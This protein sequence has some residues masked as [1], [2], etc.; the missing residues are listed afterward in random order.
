MAPFSGCA[1][2]ARAIMQRA[3]VPHCNRIKPQGSV[4]ELVRT[5]WQLIA[6]ERGPELVAGHLAARIANCRRDGR[7]RSVAVSADF[8]QPFVSR[9]LGTW[10]TRIA[11]FLRSVRS[12]LV[13]EK[14]RKSTKHAGNGIMMNHGESDNTNLRTEVTAS[15]DVRVVA[16]PH[17]PQLLVR[18]IVQ[19]GKAVLHLK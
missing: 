5:V 4:C 7:R 9:R 8:V 10:N 1:P 16:R 3:C 17:A 14:R 19:S 2:A 6:G 11:G 13:T 12:R 15:P 18:S